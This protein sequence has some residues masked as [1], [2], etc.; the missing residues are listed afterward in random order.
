[1][2]R[3]KRATAVLTRCISDGL[4]LSVRK[5]YSGDFGSVVGELFWLNIRA[6]HMR[7]RCCDAV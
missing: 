3:N 2:G 7:K 5:V 1:M 4:K 6:A